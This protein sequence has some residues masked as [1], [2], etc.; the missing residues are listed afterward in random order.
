MI[1]VEEHPYKTID[2]LGK[3]MAYVSLRK[4]GR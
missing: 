1:S 4:A 3:Q 2:V